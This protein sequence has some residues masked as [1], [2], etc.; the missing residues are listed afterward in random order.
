[1]DNDGMN[2]DVERSAPVGDLEN[3]MMESAIA[4]KKAIDN[5]SAAAYEQT[6][7]G[8]EGS[9]DDEK[10][11][12]DIGSDSTLHEVHGISTADEE[13]S[14]LQDEECGRMSCRVL[15]QYTTTITPSSKLGKDHQVKIWFL[16]Q[17]TPI[18]RNKTT[19]TANILI[20]CLQEGHLLSH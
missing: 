15:G 14:F 20:M 13:E 10:P 17:S 4:E 16:V 5:K 6:S 9:D 19:N 2:G 12:S 3:W 11:S 8:Q 1:M 18:V 7:A